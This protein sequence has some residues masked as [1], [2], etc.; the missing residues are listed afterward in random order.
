MTGK[1]VRK[2][3][4]Q[5]L[6]LALKCLADKDFQ[7]RVWIRGEGP[8][9]DSFDESVNIFFDLMDCIHSSQHQY[10]FSEAQL[11][12]ITDFSDEFGEFSDNH[13]D[14]EEFI[15]TPEWDDITK[16]AKEVLRAFE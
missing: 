13:D 10:R 3:I 9:V 5:H 4:L 12:A 7:K 2:R 14:P 16:K 8:E 6:L 15:D 11:D 1:K